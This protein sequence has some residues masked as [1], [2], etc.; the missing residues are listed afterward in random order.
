MAFFAKTTRMPAKRIPNLIV[1]EIDYEDMMW[2]A[3]FRSL[4]QQALAAGYTAAEHKW[5][6]NVARKSSDTTTLYWG[7][8]MQARLRV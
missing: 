6:W 1:D 5:A 2:E 8:L 3:M 4:Q 7:L